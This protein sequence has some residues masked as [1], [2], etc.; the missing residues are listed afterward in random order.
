[1]SNTLSFLMIKT[2]LFYRFDTFSYKIVLKRVT[3]KMTPLAF[4][5]EMPIFENILSFQSLSLSNSFFRDYDGFL[6]SYLLFYRYPFIF[7]DHGAKQFRI[8]APDTSM[9]SGTPCYYDMIRYRDPD[10]VSCLHHTLSD[11][12]IRSDRKSVV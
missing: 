4:L 11:L 2:V 6:F 8:L 3:K 9:K 10:D 12:K 1:M 5:L 7:C